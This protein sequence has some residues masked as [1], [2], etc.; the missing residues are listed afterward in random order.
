MAI[1]NEIV[2]ITP[3]GNRI[4]CICMKMSAECKASRYRILDARGCYAIVF[5]LFNFTMQD[6]ESLTVLSMATVKESTFFEFMD[7]VI[8]RLEQLRRVGTV[9][10]YCAALGSFSRFRKGEDIALRSV[11]RIVVEDYQTYL[12]SAG[13]A[14]N[15]ISFYMRILRAVYRRAVDQ[16]LTDDR[17]PF[18]S[19]F[20]GTEKTHNRAVSIADI[21]RIRHIDLSSRPNL[22]F[23]RDIFMFIFFCRGMSFIDAAF[24]KKTDIQGGVLVY[25]RHKTG[26]E[27]HVKVVKPISELI[28]RYTDEDSP[29]LLPIVSSLSATDVRLQYESAL[30]RVNNSLKI[31]ADMAKL[32]I[33]LTTYVARHSWATI[34]KAKNVPVGVISDALGHES[35]VTTQIY[36]ASI[37]ASAIDRANELVIRDL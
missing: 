27:L 35:L 2:R 4:L 20:T 9:K 23:A 28:D 6:N 21:R 25:R 17:R 33:P 32:P 22:E 14:P 8:V 24:L 1:E 7:G 13:L 11:D 16:G 30:R 34:A 31:I 10:N 36:L 19:V 18:R 29:Y 26:Q 3:Q 5:V 12:K 15:S 37:D